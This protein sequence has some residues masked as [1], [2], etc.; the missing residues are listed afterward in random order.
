MA[1]LLIGSEERGLR[2]PQLR[3]LCR[4]DAEFGA[5]AVERHVRARTLDDAGAHVAEDGPELSA[6]AV[7][8]ARV[9]DFEPRDRFLVQLAAAHGPVEQVLQRAREAAGVLRS[10]E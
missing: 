6:G 2:S 4:R 3:L 10:G 9:R 5:A 8:A 7:T 1:V